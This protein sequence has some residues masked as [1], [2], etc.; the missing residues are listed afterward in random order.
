VSRSGRPLCCSSSR[1]RIQSTG[2]FDPN[3][4]SEP[5]PTSSSLA[6]R[7]PLLRSCLPPWRR[8]VS[9]FPTQSKIER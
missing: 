3:S 4:G 9:R 6:G 5:P 8:S 1:W 7:V 2:R